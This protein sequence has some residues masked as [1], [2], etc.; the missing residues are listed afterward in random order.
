MKFSCYINKILWTHFED[1]DLVI[2]KQMVI[3]VFERE[4]IQPELNP[5]FTTNII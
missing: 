1:S 5:P 3:N 2:V 4:K